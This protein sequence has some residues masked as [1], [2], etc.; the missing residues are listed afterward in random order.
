MIPHYFPRTDLTMDP[1]DVS[2]Q[3]LYEESP[4]GGRAEP[5]EVIMEGRA[6]VGR[7]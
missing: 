3:L 6:P 2:Y 7:G 1:D 5:L 4:L